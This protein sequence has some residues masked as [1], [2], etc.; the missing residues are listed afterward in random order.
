MFINYVSSP[1]GFMLGNGFIIAYF[2]H[3]ATITEK[4]TVKN[5]PRPGPVQQNHENDCPQKEDTKEAK[6]S[7]RPQMSPVE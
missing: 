1:L 5:F 6:F 7:R 3:I 2:H 4:L